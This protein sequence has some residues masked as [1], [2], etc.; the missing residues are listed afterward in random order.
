MEVQRPLNKHNPSDND[1]NQ[2]QPNDDMDQLM[3]NEGKSTG[4]FGGKGLL[5][6]VS[7]FASLG[8]FL[9]GYDQGV[10][11]GI[12][13]GPYFQA[14]FQNP[15]PV[16]IGT[17]VSVLEIG[18]FVT[19]LIAGKLAD[20]KG[21]TFT[22]GLGSFIFVI[23]G[24][25]QTFTTGFNSMIVG[26]LVSGFGVG[27]LSMIVPCY[28]AEVSPA[29]NRG[30]LGCVE[31]TGNIVGYASSVWIDYFASFLKSDLSWRIPL[32][33]P[34]PFLSPQIHSI[35]GVILAL[36][37]L[38]IPESPRHLIAVGRD[39]EGIKVI[40]ALRGKMEDDIE[41]R[42]EYEGVR[43]VVTADKAIND[44]SYKALWRRYRG[45]V[46]IAASSQMFAQLNG[47]NVVSY[48]APLVF[49]QAGWIGRDA[50]LMTGINGIIYVLSTIPTW[51]LVDRMGRRPIL[52]SGAVVMSLALT[53]VGY[54]M[55]L[56]LAFTP[57]AVVVCVII[58]NAAFGASWGPL[59]WLY[60]PEIMPLA[61]R[62][63][64]VSISTATDLIA[65]RLYPVHAFFC[66]CSFVV[67]YFLY[68][69]T[70]GVPLENM[71]ELFG[72]EMDDPD[73]DSDSESGDSGSGFQTPSGYSNSRPNSRP[74]SR[75]SSPGP[76]NSKG[77][78]SF[79]R[80]GAQKSAVRYEALDQETA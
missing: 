76:A 44:K 14:Y 71:N 42:E 41:V 70:C 6:G 79:T 52:L 62:A 21:R 66:I 55:Y 37:S 56:D 32:S 1:V 22:I 39:D 40:A 36:G 12:I 78:L 61:F 50:I 46:L 29:H 68:P 43:D 31:F 45:R 64:G 27:M 10:M 75:T 25:L 65:W 16:K 77:W 9:F 51:Y 53:G 26:R 18:A 38:V 30:L 54:F 3:A 13:T 48:Y 63:K 47:I 24:A 58:F 33:I 2:E 8:V 74:G 5:Y 67:V 20:I 23:G 7:T 72:D 34:Q 49:E 15:D 35:I 4:V 11:S 57:N 80:R 59:P 69:E 28:Q 60:P 19:S 17:M 73:S